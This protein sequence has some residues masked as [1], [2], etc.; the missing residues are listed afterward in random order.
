L[1]EQVNESSVSLVTSSTTSTTT[2]V[3]YS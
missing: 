3:D 1:D 2:T